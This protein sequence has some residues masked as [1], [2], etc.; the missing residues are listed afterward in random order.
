MGSD[1]KSRAAILVEQRKPLIIDEI[2]LPSLTFGQVRVRIEA[3]GICGSQIGEIDGVK[4]EDRWLPHLLGHEACGM[5]EE[6]GDCVKT[7]KVGDRVVL[8]KAVAGA[9]WWKG[10]VSQTWADSSDSLS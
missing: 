7:V 9:P 6:V 8:L 5:V 1:L 10:Q 4:G 3:S 2:E